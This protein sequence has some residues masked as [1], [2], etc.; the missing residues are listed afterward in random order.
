MTISK[1]KKALNFRANAKY[2]TKD[3]KVGLYTGTEPDIE[4]KI[5]KEILEETLQEFQTKKPAAG[6]FESILDNLKKKKNDS[7][8]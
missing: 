2:L 7:D 1:Y 4:S 8:V 5:T 6:P 3:F